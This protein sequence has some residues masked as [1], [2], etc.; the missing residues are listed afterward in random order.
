MIF[1][2]A[3]KLMRE[4]KKITHKFLGEDVYLSGCYITFKTIIDDDGKEWVDS[5]EDAKERGMNIIKCK[6]DSESHEMWGISYYVAKIKRQ[7]KKILTEED[8]KKYHNFYTE[9]DIAEIFDNDIFKFPQ[10]NLLLIM[11]DDWKIYEDLK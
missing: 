11:S 2:E 1:E 7:L 4:G 8:Y 6:G 3:L 9:M 10:L 5:F